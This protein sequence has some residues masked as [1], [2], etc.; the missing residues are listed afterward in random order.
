M[1]DAVLRIVP[2]FQL[3]E[4]CII[5]FAV[6]GGWPIFESKVGIVRVMPRDSGLRDVIAHPSDRLLQ[7]RRM[8][9]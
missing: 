2:L 3:L 7:N 4:A 6:I 5:F 9:G 8:R 1:A